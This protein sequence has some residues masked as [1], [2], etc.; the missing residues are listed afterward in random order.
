MQIR[1]TVVAY[2]ATDYLMEWNLAYTAKKTNMQ[3]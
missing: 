2:S 3:I 1:Y